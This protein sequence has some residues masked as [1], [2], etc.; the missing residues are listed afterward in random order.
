MGVLIVMPSV[1]VIIPT[2]NRIQQV[3]AAVE[4]VLIQSFKSFELI[5]VD[6]GSSDGTEERLR[7][8]FDSTIRLIRQPPAGVSA[9]RNKG[10]RH[11]N[12]EF[13]AFLDSDDTWHRDKLKHQIDFHQQNPELN[14]SQ[15][16]E[17][18][19]RRGRFVN[20]HKKHRKPA[21]YIFPQSLHLCTVS[22]SSVLI[23]KTVFDAAGGFD[24]RLPACEDYDLWLR[25]TATHPVGL[26][27]MR[28]LT[29]HGGHADQLSQKYPAMDRFRL[30]SLCKIFLSDDLDGE[31]KA[32]IQQVGLE[33]LAV[34]STGAQKRGQPAAPLNE[35]V[36][37]VFSQRISMAQFLPRAETLLLNDALYS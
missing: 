12:G 19:I 14:L 15:T 28:L 1:S 23:R 3:T 13:L 35:L 5:V 10:A 4:S 18:W 2:H 16:E 6:D 21:G 37:D 25:I 22:P 36:N 9:A 8:L 29:K 17:T 32:Q 27:G 30:Y 26:I 34:L 33:K 7:A 20:P 11:S 24:E 31:Q